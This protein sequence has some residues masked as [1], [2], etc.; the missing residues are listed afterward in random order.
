MRANLIAGLDIG[1]GSVDRVDQL[2]DGL[3]ARDSDAR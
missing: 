3:D 2:T 1:T